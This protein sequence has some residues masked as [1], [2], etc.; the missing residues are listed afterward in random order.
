MQQNIYKIGDKFL[1][2][3][4]ITDEM[5]GAFAKVS[6]DHNPVHLNDEYAA[7]TIFG[8]RI[9]HGFLV[10]SL[11]SAVLGNDYP[12]VGTI[13][14]SQRMKF[15]HPVYIEDEITIKVEIIEIPKEDR[16]LL[17]T[18]CVNQHKNIVIEGEAL[19]IPPDINQ[20]KER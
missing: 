20:L 14:L 4:L 10:G 1:K 12:G 18:S 16:L 2:T 9:A 11:I 15:L 6:G 5:I 3:R 8:K 19:V 17:R 7:K 13:Y